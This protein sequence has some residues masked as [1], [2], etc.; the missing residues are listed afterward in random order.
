MTTKHPHKTALVLIDVE[1]AFGTL[2]QRSVAVTRL[3]ALL[4]HV[5]AQAQVVAACPPARI[6]PDVKQALADQGVKVLSAGIGPNAADKVLLNRARQAAANGVTHFTVVSADA[7]FATLAALGELHV[8]AW[9]RQ[10][11][12]KTLAKAA[13]VHRISRHHSAPA[14]ASAQPAAIPRVPRPAPQR[15]APA[16][17]SPPPSAPDS[18]PI[19]RWSTAAFGVGALFCGGLAFGTGTALGSRL[20]H[21]ALDAATRPRP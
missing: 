20:V 2:A 16:P 21:L 14:S 1:N 15:F 7:A 11:V 8:L 10:P 4:E 13:T 17:A 9:D 6:R 5:P 18:P 19:P 12:G 3:A